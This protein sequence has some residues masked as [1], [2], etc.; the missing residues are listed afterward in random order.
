MLRLPPRGF[1]AQGTRS[2][3]RGMSLPW[4]PVPP[5]VVSTQHDEKHGLCWDIFHRRNP[6]LPTS[7]RL[8]HAPLSL[9][10]F[11]LCPGKKAQ[12][13]GAGGEGCST[14]WGIMAMGFYFFSGSMMTT[15][16]EGRNES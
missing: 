8:T 10:F 11:L 2:G 4:H 3:T 9:L 15:A 14:A 16:R 1:A 5:E 12:M 13:A 7:P 6:E